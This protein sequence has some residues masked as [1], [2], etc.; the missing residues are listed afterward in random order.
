LGWGIII[1]NYEII[2][3]EKS[4]PFIKLNYLIQFFEGPSFGAAN[5]VQLK[6]A[7]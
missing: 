3:D 2:Q 7:I 4:E 6:V 1:K 5:N